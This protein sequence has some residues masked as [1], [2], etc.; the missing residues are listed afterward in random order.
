MA[1]KKNARKPAPM[2]CDDMHVIVLV[3]ASQ[4][5][6]YQQY[7]LMTKEDWE[8]V[9]ALTAMVNAGR[10]PKQRDVEQ[11]LNSL[12]EAHI[13]VSDV[14]DADDMEDLEATRRDPADVH[15]VL[16]EMFAKGTS[17]GDDDEEVDSE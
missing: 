17:T 14:L 12:L 2:D 4:V 3:T 1:K 11:Q 13:D 8:R 9:K 10:T 5:V 15:L 7:R 6:R 16:E